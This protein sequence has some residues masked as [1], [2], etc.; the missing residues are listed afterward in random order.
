MDIKLEPQFSSGAAS[1]GSYSLSIKLNR[2]L[3]RSTLL[4]NIFFL[5]KIKE[6]KAKMSQSS[7][8]SAFKPVHH[9]HQSD[10]TKSLSSSSSSS[11]SSCSST[12]SSSSS[13]ISSSKHL[14]QSSYVPISENGQQSRFKKLK[15]EEVAHSNNNAGNSPNVAA[16]AAVAAAAASQMNPFYIDKIFNFQNMFL[17]SG[18]HNNNIDSN[19]QNG[20]PSSISGISNSSLPGKSS[21]TYHHSEASPTNGSSPFQAAMNNQHHSSSSNTLLATT[22]MQQNLLY[23]Y[24]NSATSPAAFNTSSFH[25]QQQQLLMQHQQKFKATTLPL[26]KE[27]A[28]SNFSIERILSLP[29]TS[30]SNT[31]TETTNKL[32]RPHSNSE[33]QLHADTFQHH[34]RPP[35]QQNLA[36][37][38][39]VLGSKQSPP[40]PLV[41]SNHPHMH[42]SP[43]Y[44]AGANRFINTNALTKLGT[45]MAITAPLPP[46]MLNMISS[47]ANKQHHM[48]HAKASH[49]QSSEMS[50]SSQHFQGP[51]HVQQPQA[52]VVV[53]SKNAKKYK[54]DLCGRGFS[55][56]NTLITHRV[57]VL[58][59]KRMFRVGL[60]YS[61]LCVLLF[62]YPPKILKFI[63]SNFSINAKKYPK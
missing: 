36:L 19:E 41:L 58:H 30:S 49:H 6:L 7:Q 29:S 56:S 3:K 5:L 60:N 42:Y 16:I 63:P 35:I 4:K 47:N 20:P 15:N 12:S 22:L 28:K 34:S 14:K 18:N 55:R 33:F 31:P 57:S 61:F 52:P 50:S 40:P 25:Q 48:R 43:K 17:F 59:T 9:L 39:P 1:A 21:P 54:C 38:L 37:P 10:V 2:Y 27:A 62:W 51:K 32:K 8:S 53:K 44:N 24:Y 11:S 46:S 13:S 26:A 23:N 45:P